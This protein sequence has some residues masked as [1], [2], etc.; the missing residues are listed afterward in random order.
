MLS[1]YTAVKGSTVVTLGADAL[2]QLSE[3]EHTVTVEFDDGEAETAITVKPGESEEKEDD[4][5]DTGNEDHMVLFTV[6]SFIS[7]VSLGAVL[8]LK[9]ELLGSK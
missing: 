7:A 4:V 5:P 6:I 9:K 3:G 2:E 1:A 8:T